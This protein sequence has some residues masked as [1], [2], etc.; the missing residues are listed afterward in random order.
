MTCWTQSLHEYVVNAPPQGD[1]EDAIREFLCTPRS[2]IDRLSYELESSLRTWIERS[3]DL[4]GLSSPPLLLPYAQKFNLLGGSLL[5]WGLTRPWANQIQV[6]QIFEQWYDVL[7]KSNSFNDILALN[8][9]YATK[10]VRDL[11]PTLHA[12]GRLAIADFWLNH[13]MRTSPNSLLWRIEM[14]SPTVRERVMDAWCD[15]YDI[16][17]ARASGD[18]G[19]L[20]WLK[21]VELAFQKIGCNQRDIL[22]MLLDNKQLPGTAKVSA[23]MFVV[24]QVWLNLD[25]SNVLRPII[26]N[27]FP[28]PHMRV[29]HLPWTQRTSTYAPENQKNADIHRQICELYCPE[30]TPL[31]TLVPVDWRDRDNVC[32]VAYEHRLMNTDTLPVVG[33]F[34]HE[35]NL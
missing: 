3:H 24:P 29:R 17:Q 9:A 19:A 22:L 18:I 6:Q 4:V 31:F 21:C 7:N 35:P 16:A 25:V 30:L 5:T 27:A 11:L 8:M 34:D 15:V 1:D 2:D 13:T 32:A 20:N 26:N 28:T 12:P 10:I 23:A 33:L 14:Y